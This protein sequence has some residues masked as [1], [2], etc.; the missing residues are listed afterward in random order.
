M[1]WYK[2]SKNKAI[3]MDTKL[4]MDARAKAG[5]ALNHDMG[6]IIQNY[7]IASGFG[8][9]KKF[10][11]IG[12]CL[13]M[14]VRAKDHKQMRL[15]IEL[16]KGCKRTEKKAAKIDPDDP[17]MRDLMNFID[18]SFGKPEVKINDSENKRPGI[19]PHSHELRDPGEQT[20]E[21]N[22]RMWGVDPEAECPK[23]INF[24]DI[25]IS[26]QDKRIT[27]KFYL[28]Y[29]PDEEYPKVIG[30]AT[31]TR[32]FYHS[33]AYIMSLYVHPCFRQKGLGS[34]FVN[35]IMH[36]AKEWELKRV[37]LDSSDKARPVYERMGFEPAPET[38]ERDTYLE[39]KLAQYTPSVGDIV[40]F[41][42]SS[43]QEVV[44]KF[45][46]IFPEGS[47]H[48]GK[49]RI[50]TQGR[51]PGQN[52]PYQVVTLD[53]LKPYAPQVQ[54]GQRVYLVGYPANESPANLISWDGQQG[55]VVTGTQRKMRVTQKDIRKL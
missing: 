41:T 49:A 16:A 26:Q 2:E 48:A 1:S 29:M 39:K 35:S 30:T 22:I 23:D 52:I 42:H 9:Q 28:W 51:V 3:P 46:A 25:R 4:V 13:R 27:T 21:K 36:Q 34:F 47:Y 8:D 7:Y 24:A 6:G 38:E 31:M 54:V 44:G 15:A 33:Y 55:E 11:C 10:D 43:G 5:G 40:S 18:H 20:E 50:L 45:E 32:D 12:R 53:Q 14:F 19:I 17:D 37:G